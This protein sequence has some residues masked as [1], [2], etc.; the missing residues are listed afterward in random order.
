MQDPLLAEIPQRISEILR[1]KIVRWVPPDQS[2][3]DYDGRER[4]IEIFNVPAN[5]QRLMMR[6]IRSLHILETITVIFHTPKETKRL[7]PD[8]ES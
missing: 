4:T 5:E 2:V 1:G 8:V 7:F 6:L 3:G